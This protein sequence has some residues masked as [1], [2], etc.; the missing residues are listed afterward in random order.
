MR[1]AKAVEEIS[2]H[3][4]SPAEV[5][6]DLISIIFIALHNRVNSLLSK[7]E[8]FK[9]LEEEYLRLI[10]PY[11]KRG[12]VEH[13]ISAFAA[14]QEDMEEKPY[15]DVLGVY[16][17]ELK[18]NS[19][20]QY[21]GQFFTPSAIANMMVEMTFSKKEIE[22]KGVIK[23]QEPAAG[24]GIFP[25]RTAAWLARNGLPTR[26]VRWELWEID[27]AFFKIAYINTTLWNV[28]ALVIHGD[29]LKQEVWGAYP[30]LPYVLDISVLEEAKKEEV[31]R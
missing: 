17:L 15:E 6:K 14:L 24:A 19:D 1:F 25:L 23:A 7:K 29:S 31:K 30:N 20:R 16:Y 3:G 28:P 9:T 27:D 12:L 22:E 21:R 18:A 26:A 5:A 11:K 13:L 8:E 4:F 2:Y 10:E